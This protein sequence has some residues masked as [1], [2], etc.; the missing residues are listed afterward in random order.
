M[1]KITTIANKYPLKNKIIH[2]NTN[3]DCRGKNLNIGLHNATGKYICFLDDDDDFHPNH[4]STSIQLLTLNEKSDN[5]NGWVIALCKKRRYH[6]LYTVSEEVY[7]YFSTF[8]Y[9]KLLVNN[10][11]PI[12]SFIIDRN[13]CS[14]KLLYFSEQ[15][16][17]LEDY[18]F[19]L[20]FAFYYRYPI[21]NK[22]ITNRYNISIDA[23]DNTI[24]DKNKTD[25]RKAMIWK[26]S[27]YHI[28]QLKKKYNKENVS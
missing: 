12:H 5:Y 14:E 26:D 7:R 17:V 10:F 13:K 6:G 2:H 24:M 28:K 19:L 18:Y 4:F 27:E 22:N 15:Y 1:D 21:I 25:K 8:K 20:N 3:E 11:I 16:K 9:E 23:I